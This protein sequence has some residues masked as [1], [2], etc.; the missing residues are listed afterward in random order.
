MGQIIVNPY[1]ATLSLIVSHVLT[2][3]LGTLTSYSYHAYIY[4]PSIF[5]PNPLGHLGLCPEAYFLPC[6]FFFFHFLTL[7]F[8]ISPFSIY[9]S[10]PFTNEQDPHFSTLLFLNKSS[11]FHRYICFQ[12]NFTVAALSLHFIAHQLI[13]SGLSTSS[14]CYIIE[15]FF[16]KSSQ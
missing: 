4:L 11:S 14:H 3:S 1:R 8:L 2:N 7:N 13:N 12:G 10:I 5:Y 6:F 16:L 15:S 9:S